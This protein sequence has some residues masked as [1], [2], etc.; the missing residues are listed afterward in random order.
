MLAKLLCCSGFGLDPLHSNLSFH[1]LMSKPIVDGKTCMAELI[2]C[3][4]VQ[5]I[6]LFGWFQSQLKVV[7]V[8]W[9][10]N[11]LIKTGLVVTNSQELTAITLFPLDKHSQVDASD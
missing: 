9:T 7:V 8:I 11:S 1:R 10:C 3:D 5:N 6:S 2:T 4:L